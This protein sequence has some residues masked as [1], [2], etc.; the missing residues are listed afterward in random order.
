MRTLRL[1]VVA[2]SVIAAAV[3]SIHAQTARPFR[4]HAIAVDS[5]QSMG[6]SRGGVAV[7]YQEDPAVVAKAQKERAEQ[8]AAIVA[9]QNQRNEKALVG[10]DQRIVEFLKKRIEDGSGSA[11]FDLARRHEVGH[12]VAKDPVEARRL[13][14][15]AAERSNE[16]AEKWIAA[17]P[18]PKPESIAEIAKP[19]AK[20]PSE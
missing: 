1:S 12:G 6:L 7:G 4:G 3:P 15:L 19:A 11:A 16:E 14:K 10:V 17:H 2:L 8:A 18:E 5:L 13:Y 20:K 9:A